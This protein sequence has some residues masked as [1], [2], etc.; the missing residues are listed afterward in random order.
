MRFHQ[1]HDV[2][3]IFLPLAP[4]SRLIGVRPDFALNYILKAGNEHFVSEHILA[5]SA[6]NKRL[7]PGVRSDLYAQVR[8]AYRQVDTVLEL[9]LHS[10]ANPSPARAPGVFL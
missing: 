8:S 3:Q 10:G 9:L 1:A 2:R 5:F 7:V 6:R 4:A